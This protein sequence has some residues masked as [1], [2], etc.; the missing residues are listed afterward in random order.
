M[1]I[2]FDSKNRSLFILDNFKFISSPD[3]ELFFAASYISETNFGSILEVTEIVPCPPREIRSKD[4]SSSPE[5]IAK[6]PDLISSEHCFL[7][8]S[9]IFK[10]PVAS[11]IPIIFL[12]EHSLFT[13]STSML[14]AVLEGTL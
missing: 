1:G 3:S 13:V 4:V 11:L 10:S 9:K 8:S 6:F 14:L 7:R 5:Y 2:G 12:F